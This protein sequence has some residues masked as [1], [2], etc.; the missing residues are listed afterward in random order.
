M[1][2][3]K[4]RRARERNSVALWKK[5]QGIK[6]REIL[7]NKKFAKIAGHKT[8]SPNEIMRVYEGIIGNIF[9]LDLRDKNRK[10]P[11]VAARASFFKIVYETTMISLASMGKFIGKDHAT[12]IHAVNYDESPT[13]YNMPAEMEPLYK[14]ARLA[15]I[16]WLKQKGVEVDRKID[17]S[18]QIGELKMIITQKEEEIKKI[19]LDKFSNEERKILDMYQGLT[20]EQKERIMN[21]GAAMKRMNESD[22]ARKRSVAVKTEEET[23]RE[24]LAS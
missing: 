12:A 7:F 19:K 22:A 8:I 13:K 2:T 20:V 10:T 1:Q 5:A 11:Q 3:K 18:I 14:Q 16:S 24:R 6:E 17:D 23:V 15:C 21:M 4:M 9:H